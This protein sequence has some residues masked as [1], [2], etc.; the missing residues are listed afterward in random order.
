MPFILGEPRTRARSHTLTP[1]ASR[2][3][4]SLALSLYVYYIYPL[5]PSLTVS[6]PQLLVVACRVRV[7]AWAR[8]CVSSGEMG[9]FL[10]EN[11]RHMPVGQY[12]Q[13][14]RAATAA[15]AAATARC[16][17]AFADGLGHKGDEI[18]FDGTPALQRTQTLAQTQQQQQRR[19]EGGGR[20]Y[21]LCQRSYSSLNCGWRACVAAGFHELGRR[22]ATEWEKVS[23]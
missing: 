10:V 4:S 15:T 11:G 2:F 21:A 7:R 19:R 3:S 20:P 16:S 12:V 22:Y 8:A 1:V 17:V 5:L 13:Q 14:V 6:P 23:S 18:H 9:H